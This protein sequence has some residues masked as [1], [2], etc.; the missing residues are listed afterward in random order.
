[1]R[2][3]TV[4]SPR[5]PAPFPAQGL[6][7]VNSSPAPSSLP[8]AVALLAAVQGLVLLPAVA[9]FSC[10]PAWCCSP[11]PFFALPSAAA[12][13]SCCGP[14]SSDHKRLTPLVSFHHSSA[15]LLPPC[16]RAGPWA[17]LG[18]NWTTSASRQTA[19]WFAPCLFV[20][21]PTAA[22]PLSDGPRC[23]C[24]VRVLSLSS[25]PWSWPFAPPPHPTLTRA[26]STHSIHCSWPPPPRT[27]YRTLIALGRIFVSCGIITEPVGKPE[28]PNRFAGGRRLDRL[29]ITLHQCI[30]HKP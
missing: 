24:C 2:T 25:S 30:L 20:A 18:L 22:P 10:R 26:A 11:A 1:V 8:A 28:C 23:V 16:T 6:V 13:R 7:A 14:L 5:S 3:R 21:P 17:P 29:Y 4:R 15:G 12:S 19:A 9:L 27:M